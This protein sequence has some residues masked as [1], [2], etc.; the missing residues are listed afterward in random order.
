MGPLSGDDRALLDLTWDDWARNTFANC[1]HMGDNL[2]YSCDKNAKEEQKV[3][4]NDCIRL[5]PMEC[6]YLVTG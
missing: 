3:G 6:Q 4:Q 1:H 2:N 5:S